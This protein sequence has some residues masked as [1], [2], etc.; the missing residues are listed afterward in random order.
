MTKYE[1]YRMRIQKLEEELKYRKSIRYFYNLGLLTDDDIDL[2]LEI[3][4]LPYVYDENYAQLDKL[5][6]KGLGDF[7]DEKYI[8]IKEY[9]ELKEKISLRYHYWKRLGM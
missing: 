2:L 1:N 8:Y 6:N 9:D 7:L 4:A 5:M 3:D